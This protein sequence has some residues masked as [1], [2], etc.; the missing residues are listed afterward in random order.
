MKYS[1]QDLID[2]DYFK[3]L[4]NRLNEIYSFPS[5]IIDNDGHILTATAWQE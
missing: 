1:L 3:E 2:I 5:S 4:Q